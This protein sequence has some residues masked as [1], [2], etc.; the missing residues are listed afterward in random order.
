MGKTGAA[1]ADLFDDATGLPLVFPD[2]VVQFLSSVVI[3]IDA[4]ESENL[5]ENDMQN[6]ALSL[7]TSHKVTI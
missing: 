7:F 5:N 2:T 1:P 4:K 3:V 6:T